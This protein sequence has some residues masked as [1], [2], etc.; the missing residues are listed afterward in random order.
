MCSKGGMLMLS[1][2][3]GQLPPGCGHAKTAQ[4]PG[5]RSTLYQATMEAVEEVS[6]VVLE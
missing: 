6:R 4:R 2:K 1:P 3:L 5:T